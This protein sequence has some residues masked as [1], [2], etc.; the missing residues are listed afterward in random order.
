APASPASL[1]APPH[2]RAPAPRVPAPR[3]APVR[4]VPWRA[5][6]GTRRAA[7]ASGGGGKSVLGSGGQG[8]AGRRR[9]GGGKNVWTVWNLLRAL[10]FQSV[11]PAAGR[12][13]LDPEALGFVGREPEPNRE[14][15][16]Q[17]WGRAPV[18]A[19]VQ[20]RFNCAHCVNQTALPSGYPWPKVKLSPCSSTSPRSSSSTPSLR[21]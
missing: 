16:R 9:P 6:R 8:N 1:P 10:A 14:F 15:T 4:R 19:A 17:Q 5:P 21:R 2:R 3:R 13:D 18:A 7:A 11:R 12:A 20:H